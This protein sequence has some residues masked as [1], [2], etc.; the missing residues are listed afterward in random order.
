MESAMATFETGQRVPCFFPTTKNV[1]TVAVEVVGCR[2]QYL[3]RLPNDNLTW[4]DEVDLAK[5]ARRS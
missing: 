2:G 3:V 5:G 4:V 1:V